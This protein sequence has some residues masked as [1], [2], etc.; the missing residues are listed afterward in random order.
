MPSIKVTEEDTS[1]SMMDTSSAKEKISTNSMT[2]SG[3]T[4]GPESF[5]YAYHYELLPNVRSLT[6][7]IYKTSDETN[8]DSIN[9]DDE[10]NWVP[11]KLAIDPTI[12]TLTLT[13]ANKKT[14]TALKFPLP[15]KILASSSDPKTTSQISQ[16]ASGN[17]G[18][19]LKF[20]LDP[21]LKPGFI[22][23]MGIM[24]QETSKLMERLMF[25]QEK[26]RRVLEA[27]D[28]RGKLVDMTCVGCGTSLLKCGSEKEEDPKVNA[29]VDNDEEGA[30]LTKTMETL[31]LSPN[32]SSS[33]SCRFNRIVDLPSE[34]WAELLDC[35]MCH[36]ENFAKDRPQRCMNL[37][38][39]SGTLYIGDLSV[40]L[41][42]LDVDSNT[43]RVIG[44]EKN[45]ETETNDIRFLKE[46]SRLH[47][48]SL[49]HHGSFKKA[50]VTVKTQSVAR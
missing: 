4:L 48:N 25:G 39:E 23:Q 17:G 5:R 33:S 2:A 11:H 32:A 12:I 14:F 24:S 50:S 18:L 38:A 43:M 36:Q 49:F 41:S 35:W 31:S 3:A 20:S 26:S 8:S 29:P 27:K 30:S 40:V 16:Q 46:V 13:N 1:I 21:P 34:H 10:S 28:L 6:Y 7:Y 47:L 44:A 9:K 42:N 37:E 19:V 22:S 15:A 45:S